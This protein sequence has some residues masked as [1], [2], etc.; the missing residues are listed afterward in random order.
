MLLF[1]SQREA[2]WGTCWVAG[3]SSSAP[4]TRAR[5]R[6][7]GGLS[8]RNRYL[9]RES[10]AVPPQPLLFVLRQ[11]VEPGD[12]DRPSPALGQLPSDLGGSRCQLAALR[13]SSSRIVSVSRLRG[14]PRWLWLGTLPPAA[15]IV[16]L[17]TQ[18]AANALYMD[19]WSLVGATLLRAGTGGLSL[20]HLVAQ[21]NESRPFFPRILFLA[22]GT[23]AHGDARWLLLVTAHLSFGTSSLDSGVR[24]PVSRVRRGVSGPRR[25][26]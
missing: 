19:D 24:R 2:S 23:A 11:A 7:R 5:R 16:V 10:S 1:Q 13:P 17:L 6:R 12:Q 21:H 22:I 4:A 25:S 9:R 26:R 3:T 20:E 14:C 8:P 15:L 18:N